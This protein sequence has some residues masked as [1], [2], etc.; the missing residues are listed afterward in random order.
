LI[1]VSKRCYHRFET[2]E[3]A[4]LMS[5]SVPTADE[6]RRT[7]MERCDA[8]CALTGTGMSI[9]SLALTN[10]TNY[11]AFMRGGQRN[12]T[13]RMIEKIMAGLDE[14]EAAPQQLTIRTARE[15]VDAL[16]GEGHG[17]TNGNKRRRRESRAVHP[18][19]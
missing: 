7:V 5:N 8:Y 14:L 19:D 10:S 6:I 17:K 1:Y 2:L 18:A 15:R 16:K 12:V 4:D 13:I 11:L 9:L 3:A